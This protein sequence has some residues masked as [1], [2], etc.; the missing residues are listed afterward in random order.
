MGENETAI[1]QPQENPNSSLDSSKLLLRPCF[2]FVNYLKGMLAQSFIM[3]KLIDKNLI[4]NCHM[5]A[6]L[7]FCAS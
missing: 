3:C 5:N 1:A 4:P 7:V 2:S 6:S